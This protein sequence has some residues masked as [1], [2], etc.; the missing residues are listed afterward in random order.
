MKI[1]IIARGLKE[2]GVLRFIEN[3]LKQF[4]N[5]SKISFTIFCD[6]DFNHKYKNIK[7]IK[8]KSKNRLFIDHVLITWFL[9][10]NNFD[11]IIYPK[12]VIP[13]L[14]FF[15]KHK[16]ILIIH[17]LAHFEKNL[18]AYK[19]LDTMYMKLLIPISC[20]ISTKIIAVSKSTKSETIKKLKIKSNKIKVIY[21]GIEPFFKKE[22]NKPVVSN[23]L[24]KYNL[25]LPF[26]FY[27]GS[28]SPRKNIFNFLLAF[29]NIKDKIP[30]NIYLA[31]G[32]SWSDENVL[33]FI[34]K[35]L[36]SRVIRL[37][38]VSNEDLR[39]FYS[40]A[41][42]YTYPSLYEGFGLPIL[43]S[44]A[45]GC[46]IL[47]SN[48]T[49]CPEIAGKGALIVDVKSIKKLEY[50]IFE[51]ANNKISKDK[52]VRMG[53]ENVKNFSWNITSKEILDLIYKEVNNK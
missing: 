45:C 5:N 27:C 11:A 6:L 46:P 24:K 33:S 18:N 7:I 40:T 3:I 16:K 37:G 38:H 36:K 26:I 53:Y 13:P 35:N 4:D 12:N 14:H 9:A 15:L 42:F 52:L 34:N 20:R 8:F 19:F 43:E 41:D 22:K 47:T 44:Q 30:H 29:N 17:D 51:L 32:K 1:G 31:G 25:K 10:R 48:L 23:F 50:S 28:L 49:S 2:G 39:L 21:E